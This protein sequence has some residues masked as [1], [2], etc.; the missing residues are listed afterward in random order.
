MGGVETLFMR[1]P[2]AVR[3]G[4]RTPKAQIIIVRL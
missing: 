3:I 4:V 2:C 1:C